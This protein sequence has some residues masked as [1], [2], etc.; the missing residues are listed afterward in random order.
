LLYNKNGV[1]TV[2]VESVKEQQAQIDEL[3]RL[4]VKRGLLTNEK[5]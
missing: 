3:L 5:Q 1:I 4:A 2:L